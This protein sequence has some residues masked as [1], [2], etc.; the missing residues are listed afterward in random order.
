M[1]ATSS[2]GAG[3]S[4]VP[5]IVRMGRR[6][7][8]AGRAGSLAC[9]ALALAVAAAMPG[10]ARAQAQCVGL[11]DGLRAPVGTA[12]TNQGRLLI[13]EAGDG[14][15]GSGRISILD[16]NGKRRTL[17]DGLPSGPA[18]VGTP[19]GPSGLLMNGRSLYLA[20]GTGDTGVMGPR[21]GTTLVNLAGPSSP[22]FSSVLELFFTGRTEA[23]TTGFTMTRD[24]QDALAHGRLVSLRD[25]GGNYLSIRMVSDLPNF[26]PSPLPDVPDNI[27]AT[28]PFA[29]AGFGF[30]FYLNDGGRNS[31]WQVN[32]F[33]GAASEL[34]SYPDIPNPLFGTIGGPFIQAVPTGINTVGRQLL[35]SLFRGAPFATGVST[36]ET[37]DPF[38]GAHSPVVT[39]LT[40]GIDTA[41]DRHRGRND[42]LIL[43]MA[44]FGPFFAGPG[45]LLR[46]PGFEGAPETVADCLVAPTSMSLDRWTRTMYVTQ[47]DG[48]VVRVPLH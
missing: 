36:V 19:S 31:T 45:T 10:T 35:V 13:A 46:I 15:A 42:L 33:T 34:A 47:Q 40:T 29:I 21:A 25:G 32:R 7:R 4:T 37:L 1:V 39:G 22:I 2:M 24:N 28:N 5:A 41:V 44:G 14:S 26:T 43:E 27:H 20:M 48:N 38:T 16:R 3:V 30:S 8:R 12:L 17:I 6:L 18:D 11:L 9:C 23:R